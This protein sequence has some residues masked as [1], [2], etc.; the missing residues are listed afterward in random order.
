MSSPLQQSSGESVIQSI[1]E[2]VAAAH[3]DESPD[4]DPLYDVVEPEALTTLVKNGFTG[5]VR[6]HYE[7]CSI[8]VDGDGQVQVTKGTELSAT[9]S[10]PSQDRD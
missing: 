5:S 3:D 9:A 10:S 6:F 8:S 2:Q 1:V 4:L 7:G